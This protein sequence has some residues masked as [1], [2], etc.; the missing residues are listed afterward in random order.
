M[1]ERSARSAWVPG[2]SMPPKPGKSERNDRDL[3]LAA[4]KTRPGALKCAG[5][6]RR[7]FSLKCAHKKTVF[8]KMRP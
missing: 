7:Q 4:V 6:V 2:G 3:L 5:P 1:C 8:A